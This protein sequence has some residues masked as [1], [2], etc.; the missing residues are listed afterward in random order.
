MGNRESKWPQFTQ[1][2][3]LHDENPALA[4]GVISR[5]HMKIS[6]VLVDVAIL[7]N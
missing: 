1:L 3:I 6:T 7:S 5:I 2:Y 4:G